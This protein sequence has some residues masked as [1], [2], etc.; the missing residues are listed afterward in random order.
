MENALELIFAFKIP[1]FI[2]H[3]LTTA[4]T[5]ITLQM[6][7]HCLAP[8]RWCTIINTGINDWAIAHG[9]LILY[10]NDFNNQ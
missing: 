4:K 10:I 6:Q 2:L 8:Y 7:K 3:F 9:R 5:D 1:N